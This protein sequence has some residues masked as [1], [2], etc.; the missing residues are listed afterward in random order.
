MRLSMNSRNHAFALPAEAGPHFTNPGGMEGWVKLAG[1]L[2]NSIV[3]PFE[4]GH[5]SKY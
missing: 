4:D 2:H 5:P 3:Y 1:W